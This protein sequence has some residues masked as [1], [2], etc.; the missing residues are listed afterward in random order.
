MFNI[1]KIYNYYKDSKEKVA[2]LE[3]L[4][5][6]QK[7]VI[8]EQKRFM[9]DPKKI[10]ENCFS[11]GIAWFDYEEQA[12]ELR[13]KYYDEAQM[14]LNSQV[15]NNEKNYLIAT[16]AETALL[17]ALTPQQLRDFQMTINGLELFKTRLEEIKDPFKQETKEHIHEGM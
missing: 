2:L 17:E 4:A 7:E 15:F 13:K 16:G 1:F 11:K 14:I 5:E 9:S 3:Q 12:Q 10:V 8:E 6:K